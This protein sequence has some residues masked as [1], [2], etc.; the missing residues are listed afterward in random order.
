MEVAVFAW[1]DFLTAL[2][3]YCLTALLPYCP[4]PLLPYSPPSFPHTCTS[5]TDS[6]PSSARMRKAAASS[7]R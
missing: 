3:P 7:A 4:T 5:P 2:L 6:S 1:P